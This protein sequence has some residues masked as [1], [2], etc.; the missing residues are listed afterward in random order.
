M[1]KIVFYN[2][3]GFTLLELVIVVLVVAILSAVAL[4]Q[5]Q[6]AVAKSRY[7]S[8][9][10]IAKAIGLGQEHFYLTQGHY[11]NKLADLDVSTTPDYTADISVALHSDN[12]SNYVMTTH[13]KL[14]NTLVMYNYHSAHYPAHTYCEAKTDDE[15]AQWICEKALTGT[16]IEGG[17]ITP[18]YTAYM[19][20]GDSIS[21]EDSGVVVHEPVSYENVSGTDKDN[22]LDLQ[23]GDTCNATQTDGCKYVD[24]SGAECNA[25]GKNGCSYSS[26]SDE[27]TCSASAQGGCFKSKFKDSEC[28]VYAAASN[29]NSTSCG[30][31]DKYSD[32]SYYDHSKCYN[33]DSNKN[34]FG[35]GRSLYDN[36]SECF[37]NKYGGCGNS[38]YKNGSVCYAEGTA[39]SCDYAKFYTG[40]SCESSGAQGCIEAEF[41]GGSVCYALAP[42]GCSSTKYDQDSY[43]DGKEGVVY[44]PEGKPKN[45]AQGGGTWRKCDKAH[46]DPED[47]INAGMSC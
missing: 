30:G 6:R 22:P 9:F 21:L 12:Y 8:M 39:K 27:S 13:K 20:S 29:A 43:C 25:N 23:E 24:A 5:Y 19:L 7:K 2:F 44:C 16:K 41:Y 26:F 38:S 35:C 1:K 3:D 40:S 33:E 32:E 45:P 18:G 11:A 46:G 34:G 4:P 17:S 15:V 42:K 14:N 47:K 36:G 37:S 28:H 10:P 31:S